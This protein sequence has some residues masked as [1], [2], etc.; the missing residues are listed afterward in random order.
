[1]KSQE[2]NYPTTRSA[3]P[4]LLVGT[5]KL[6]QGITFDDVLLMPKKSEV[7]PDQVE[8]NSQFSRRIK[9]NIP[10]VSSPMDTVTESRLAIALALEGGLGVIHKNLTPR[11]QAEE[12]A[13]VKRFRNGLIENPI[14]LS[15]DQTIADAVKIRKEKGYKNIPITDQQGKLIGLITK[16]DY[17]WPEDEKMMIKKLMRP[18]SKIL[19]APTG[20][21]L[22][23]AQQL[24]K[25]RK[26]PILLL[27]DGRGYLKGIVTRSDLEKNLQYPLSNKDAQD[28]LRVAAAIGVGPDSYQ[29]ALLLAE[30]NVDA[31]IIDTAHGHSKNVL[32]MLKKLKSEKRFKDLDIV[33]GN[34]AT[35]EGARDLIEAGADAIKVG[36]GPGSICTTRI[37]AG[38]GVPQI[39]AIQ[40]AVLGRGHKNIPIIADGGVKYS[41]DIVKALAAGANSVMIG[42]LFAAT[43]ESPGEVTYFNGQIYKVYRG[44]G[45]LEAMIQGSKDRY[46]QTNIKDL[47]KLVPEGIVGQTLYKGKL[48]DHVYQL[49]GGLK[50]GMGYV[51]A[52]NIQELQAKAEFIQITENSLRES[53]PH[54]VT[55]TKEAPNYHRLSDT[56]T[57]WSI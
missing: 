42:Q 32:A 5:P 19:T 36:I 38:V 1:M 50:S 55:I 28:R 57:D 30:K 45:S 6:R 9:L 46:G 49:V 12:V 17:F 27:V 2:F 48:A 18:L 43:E 21:S 22:N 40:N 11:A 31:L 33:A 39:T 44:M 13:M 35:P 20:T 29:R 7:T 23:K 52:K 34:V 8:V 51:G 4:R 25:Q 16:F 24:I 41:G 37:I 54:D 15:P 14:T 53:H 26:A 56:N 47:N 3:S 10:L